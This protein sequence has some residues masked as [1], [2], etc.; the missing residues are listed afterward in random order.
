MAR[1]A[2]FRWGTG[3]F[4]VLDRHGMVNGT[5]ARLVDGCAFSSAHSCWAASSSTYMCSA[6]MDIE[7]QK[8]PLAPPNITMVQPEY[9]GL[10]IERSLLRIRARLRRADWPGTMQCDRRSLGKLQQSAHS[11]RALAPD[12]QHHPPIHPSPSHTPIPTKRGGGFSL[13]CV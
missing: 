2:R 1:C 5:V 7:S 10:V 6:A 8:F 11:G 12:A 4:L 9:T 13:V 3:W